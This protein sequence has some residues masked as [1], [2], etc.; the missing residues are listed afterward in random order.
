MGGCPFVYSSFNSAVYHTGLTITPTQNSVIAHYP[1]LSD[2]IDISGNNDPM[3]L[4]NAPFQNGGV[5]CNGIYDIGNPAGC[6]VMTPQNLTGF[7]PNSFEISMDF[8]LT[9]TSNQSSN[10]TP[11]FIGGDSYRWVGFCQYYEGGSHKFSLLTNNSEYTNTQTILT[12]NQW[13]NAKITYN[14]TTVQAF[15]NNHLIYSKNIALV[16]GGDYNI[17]A[18]NYSNGTIFKGYLKEFESILSKDYKNTW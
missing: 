8:M 1:L 14:G 2:G 3:T 17:G 12:I 7:S 13:N 5:Y 18:T 6:K 10:P 9:A 11:I 15:L 4:I 16:M